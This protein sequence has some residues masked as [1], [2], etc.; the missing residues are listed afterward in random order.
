M[1]SSVTG[2]MGSSFGSKQQPKHGV[3]SE[4]RGHDL[5]RSFATWRIAS[6]CHPSICGLT[7]ADCQY[8]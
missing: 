8:E 3:F 2:S 7:R 4:Q 5:L 6:F 1:A